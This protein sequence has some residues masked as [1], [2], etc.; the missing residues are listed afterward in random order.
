MA[1]TGDHWTI[2]VGYGCC[3]WNL[4]G[5]LKKPFLTS[6]KPFLFVWIS[7]QLP[8]QFQLSLIAIWD[9]HH[10][11]DLL[12][13]HLEKNRKIIPSHGLSQWEHQKIT[14]KPN[15][16]IRWWNLFFYN[17]VRVINFKYACAATRSE[18]W[19]NQW[20]YTV[21][22]MMAKWNQPSELL[23]SLAH[24]HNPS[25][26]QTFKKAFMINVLFY[27]VHIGPWLTIP[28]YS[29]HWSLL[30]PLLVLHLRV[31]SLLYLLLLWCFTHFQTATAETLIFQLVST[32]IFSQNHKSVHLF[33]H[34]FHSTHIHSFQTWT[35][36]SGRLHGRRCPGSAAAP[37]HC[38]GL[39][40]R[41]RSLVGSVSTDRN[42]GKTTRS[43][44]KKN[45]KTESFFGVWS[46][47]IEQQI[48]VVFG[49]KNSLIVSSAWA[50]S[51]VFAILYVEHFMISFFDCEWWHLTS[52]FGMIQP[53]RFHIAMQDGWTSFN[54]IFMSG[55]RSFLV[56]PTTSIAGYKCYQYVEQCCLKWFVKLLSDH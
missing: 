26:K 28:V 25:M 16:E 48:V 42:W 38:L 7:F 27:T 51:S 35:T 3:Y 11:L 13:R 49:W 2:L 17:G 52:C 10:P 12:S 50:N 55:V 34:L 22:T 19:A 36:P 21:Q 1:T 14:W 45:R 56:N 18:A 46:I 23:H 15:P 47:L 39:H 30:Q 44:L 54:D 9:C 41:G 43:F 5:L 33:H 32:S 20:R 37:S 6:F 40:G 29:C 4:T 31:C 8:W 24:N 53:G